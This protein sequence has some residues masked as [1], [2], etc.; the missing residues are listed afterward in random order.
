MNNKFKKVGV[1][2]AVV[3]ALSFTAL[4]PM[5]ASAEIYTEENAP[6]HKNLVELVNEHGERIYI[7]ADHKQ[8]IKE[9]RE[10]IEQAKKEME[11]GDNS[12]NNESEP[13]NEESNEESNENNSGSSNGDSSNESNEGSNESSNQ[14]NNQESNENNT[15]DK[16]VGPSGGDKNQSEG[17]NEEQSNNSQES[18]ENDVPH[19]EVG[20][21]GGDNN[22]EENSS[23]ESEEVES[24]KDA[25]KEAEE[26]VE[27]VVSEV[28]DEQVADFIENTG[29]ELQT[30]ANE[31]D[32]FP[33]LMV[34]QAILATNYGDTAL[35]NDNIN[36]LMGI[37]GSYEGNSV[38]LLSSEGFQYYK[39]YESLEEG[40]QDYVDLMNTE[41]YE[42]SLKSN[43][44]SVSEAVSKVAKYYAVDENYE[45][46]LNSVIESQGLEKFDE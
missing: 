36:N 27:Y 4:M 22:Q 5:S 23:K 42:A 3:S 39:Q 43:S 7:E 30:V 35:A 40:L 38:K 26:K 17:S 13:G 18:S 41:V 1:S 34:A 6:F 25:E 21:S 46:K 19:K 33:S 29:K 12:S 16:E 11:D 28:S 14:G 31:N 24:E 32:I 8:E 45:Q 15:P 2:A 37:K 9:E 20:P 44:D 10:R